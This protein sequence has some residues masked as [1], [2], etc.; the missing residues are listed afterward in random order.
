MK[1]VLQSYTKDIVIQIEI[2]A[3]QIIFL[4]SS[5]CCWST[6]QLR[7]ENMRVKSL[8]SVPYFSAFTMLSGC[9]A[10]SYG[11]VWW[12]GPVPLSPARKQAGWEGCRGSPSPGHQA[13]VLGRTSHLWACL[14]PSGCHPPTSGWVPAGQTG[15]DWDKDQASS[16]ENWHGISEGVAGD[17]LC[18]PA[19]VIPY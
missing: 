16:L 7:D 19:R 1:T 13:S 8:C 17:F 6:C 10:G 3:R 11:R 14:C 15:G 9:N 5:S 4:S 2:K 12:S 18:F